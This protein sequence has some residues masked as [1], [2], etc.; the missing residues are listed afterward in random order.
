MVDV[1]PTGSEKAV[2]ELLEARSE[3]ERED[4]KQGGIAVIGPYALDATYDDIRLAEDFRLQV[5]VPADYPASLPQVKEV[6]GALDSS[7]EHLY[8]D[9]TLCLG[10]QGE[11]LLEQLEKPSLVTLLDGPV[12]S[13][14]YSYLFHERYGRYPFGDRAHGTAGILQY[15]EELFEETDPVITIKLLRAVCLD[16]YRGHLPCPCGSGIV[17]KRCHG[18]DIIRLKKS[19]AA[20]AFSFDL[21]LID[22]L[23]TYYANSAQKRNRTLSQVCRNLV[24]RRYD[25]PIR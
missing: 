17:A 19:G 8:S 23:L 3:F 13:Y 11:L 24:D 21:K 25:R 1:T 10:I 12:R 18:K 7:Y 20:T 16:R 15:Y 5:T 22:S 4:G 6:S 9:G 2:M 14:L